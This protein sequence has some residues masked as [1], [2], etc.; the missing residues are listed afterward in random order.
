LHTGLVPLHVSWRRAGKKGPS[1]RLERD[2]TP[3][4]C[5]PIENAS[6]LRTNNTQ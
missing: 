2:T 4:E 6:N 3:T 5:R 1:A